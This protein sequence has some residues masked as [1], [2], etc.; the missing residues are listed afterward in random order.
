MFSLI[1]TEEINK[2]IVN[3]LNSY[4]NSFL[5]LF[6]DSWIYNSNII[7]E[8][9]IKLTKDFESNIYL[10]LRKILSDDI[11]LWRKIE[12]DNSLSITYFVWNW[13]I[14][15]KYTEDN[16]QKVRFIEDIEFH[17]R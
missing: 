17:R 14:L 13:K 2:K 16:G 1:I 6:I 5:N 15:I 10:S 8:N 11:V 12:I 3:F 7:E 9:Y 4:L